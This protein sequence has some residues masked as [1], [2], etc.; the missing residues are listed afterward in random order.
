MILYPAVVF[1]LTLASGYPTQ[2]VLPSKPAKNHL[3]ERLSRFEVTCAV[4][5]AGGTALLGA[6]AGIDIYTKISDMVKTKSDHNDCEASLILSED[7][8]IWYQ[9][10]GACSTEASRKEIES[11]IKSAQ[12]VLHNK[13]AS[14]GCMRLNNGG[15][16]SGLVKYST[17]GGGV[18][19]LGC[20]N[21][22]EQC[23]N[24]DEL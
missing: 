4:A 17:N 22:W 10:T 13:G 21:N 18:E 14:A 8:Q 6:N 12:Q 11:A 5:T 7:T 19:K 9:T 1:L 23:A 3:E 24:H 15:S 2:L 20:P 16:Y